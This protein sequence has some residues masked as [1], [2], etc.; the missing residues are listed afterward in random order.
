LAK[1]AILST[2]KHYTSSA[3]LAGLKPSRS[4]GGV[5]RRPLSVVGFHP[6][7]EV[8]Y[9]LKHAIVHVRN[10]QVMVRIPPRNI[11]LL[12]SLRLLP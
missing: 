10:G 6:T 1:P 4:R 2:M 5:I 12:S 11:L 7:D 8:G 9:G 3:F